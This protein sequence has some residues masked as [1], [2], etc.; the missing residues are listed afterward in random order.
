MTTVGSLEMGSEFH[1]LM[2]GEF[3]EANKA[4]ERLRGDLYVSGR[5]ALAA[6]LERIP[7]RSRVWLPTYLC[8]EVR[9]YV[10][11]ELEVSWYEDYPD[12]PSPRF[13]SLQA[14]AGDYVVAQDTFGLGDPDHWASWM[15]AN[16]DVTLIEDITH[17]C[18][19]ERFLRSPAQHVFASLRKSLPV[20]DGGIVFSRTGDLR[21]VSPVEHR[22]SL[23]K[24]EAMILKASFLRGQAVDKQ[25]FRDLQVAGEGLLVQA[26]HGGCLSHTAHLLQVAS[27]SAI[28]SNWKR[29]NDRLV[30]N[31]S[32]TGIEDRARPLASRKKGFTGPFNTVLKCAD[33]AM[34]ERL[35]E[36]LISERIYPAI[37]WLP[38]PAGHQPSRRTLE[39]SQSLLT[40]PT[41]FRYSDGD[42]DRLTQ[43]V[44][45]GLRSV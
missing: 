29:N 45:K 37:H 8:P 14:L 2:D 27:M 6:I 25:S 17:H 3:L 19:Q 41:D 33:H 40:V 43:A 38:D 18:T 28:A 5:A 31:L 20:A 9:R 39:L 44:E 32:Q 42:I 26:D 13:G 21:R 22:G 4:D 1:L 34:R 16:P 10:R 35:R 24:L 36:F 15:S 23:L 30:R 7:K 12:E 11:V